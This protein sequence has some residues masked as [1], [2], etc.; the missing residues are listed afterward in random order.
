MTTTFSM[1]ADTSSPISN[2]TTLI[3]EGEERKNPK[4]TNTPHTKKT[5]HK[6]KPN[7]SE[8]ENMNVLILCHQL[9]PSQ[10]FLC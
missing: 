10:A 9:K 2:N 1:M 4:I 5:H 3:P 7:T 8:N 6:T